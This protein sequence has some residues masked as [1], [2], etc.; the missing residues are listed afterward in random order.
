MTE[1]REFW[2][3]IYTTK[4][5]NDLGWYQAI[6][7]TS[8]AFIAKLNLNKSSSIIDVGGGDSFLVDYLLAQNYK[9]ISVLDLSS[10]ALDRAKER[11][12][13]NWSL[14]NWIHSDI[15]NFDSSKSYVCWHDRATFHFLSIKSDQ[16]KYLKKCRDLINEGG[17]LLI[18]TFSRQGPKKCSGISIVQYSIEELKDFF[19]PYFKFIEGFNIDHTTPSGSK[20]NYTFC[21]FQKPETTIKYSKS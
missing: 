9:D 4:P 1:R 13:K 20:Q 16:I 7:H 12:G 14:I 6:P 2:E 17:Y 5:L 18:G 10:I 8:L 19:S 15:I 21:S 11:I 3:N